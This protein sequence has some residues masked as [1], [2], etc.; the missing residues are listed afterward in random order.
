MDSQVALTR[1][2]K[3]ELQREDAKS[4][5]MQQHLSKA[6]ASDVQMEGASLKADRLQLFRSKMHEAFG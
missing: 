1:T 3:G 2:L 6:A 4:E 5:R